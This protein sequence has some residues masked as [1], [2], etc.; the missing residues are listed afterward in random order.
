MDAKERYIHFDWAMKRMLRNKANFTVLEGL[1][2]VLLGEKIAIIELLES[3]ANQQHPHDK[4]NRVDIKAKDSKG[5]IIIVEVQNARESFYLER[6][7]YG[8]AKAV[9]EHIELGETYQKVNKVISI[10][11]VY[12]NLGKGNDYLYHGNSHFVGVHTGDELRITTKER[13]ALVE[14]SPREIFPEYYIIRVNEFNQVAR[15]PLEEWISYLKTGVIHPE[16][17][18]P[19]LK[20]AR[21]SLRYNNMSKEERQ[22][23]DE[24][25]NAVMIENDVIDT[26]KT[27]GREEGLAEGRTEGRTE[28]RA[29]GRTEVARNLKSMNLPIET[30]MQATGLTKDEIEQL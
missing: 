21:E 7:L 27:E 1:L 18:A 29:E 4:F 17:T 16:D 13:D 15:T 26:A 9:V 20:E 6:I 19:G 14:K 25:I 24:H 23:Y 11:I 28:G 8:V 12:F 10:S 3:E 22:A 5:E 30:I 2:T